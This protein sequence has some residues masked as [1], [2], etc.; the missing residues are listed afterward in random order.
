MVTN[1]VLDISSN[2]HPTGKPITWAAV[3]A[4][5]AT[6]L[7]VAIKATQGTTYTNPFY[8]ADA[9]GAQAHG[10]PVVA[11]HYAAFT[12]AA[13]EAAH[14]RYVAGPRARVLDVETSANAAWMDA[15]WTALGNPD[16]Q[17]LTYGSAS[18]LPRTL[19]SELWPADYSSNPGVGALWQAGDNLV[20][21]GIPVPTDYSVVL[22]HAE[23]A[24]VFGLASAPSGG[25]MQVVPV[26]FPTDANGRGWTLTS[27]PWASFRGAT[28]QGSY[29]PADGYWVGRVGAQERT[30]K[31]C[32]T[33][34]DGPANGTITVFVLTE[35]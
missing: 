19:K 1:V 6:V 4:A 10:I 8:A 7:G 20:V 21:A 30:G 24:T 34:M 3:A 31:V 22:T 9:A 18:T 5:P 32:L 29:P 25:T 35:G 26:P 2:N 27:I 33:A 23:F 17:D 12:T 16:T 15:F 11:Y 14:F 13:A 28:G